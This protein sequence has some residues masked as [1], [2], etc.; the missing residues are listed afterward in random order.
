MVQKILKKADSMRAV[1]EHERLDIR[2]IFDLPIEV[3]FGEFFDHSDTTICEM[4]FN[5]QR[6]TPWYRV[7]RPKSIWDEEENQAVS[8][9]VTNFSSQ[10]P[11]ITAKVSED[12]G[13]SLPLMILLWV[14]NQY[15]SKTLLSGRSLVKLLSKRFV[16]GMKP[17][18]VIQIDQ[19]ICI[20]L[21]NDSVTTLDKYVII[22]IN[23]ERVKAVIM[24]WLV[25]VEIYDPLLGITWMRLANCTQMFV[26]EKITIKRNDRKICT[27]PAQIYPIEVKLPVVVFDEEIETDE[28]TAD[29]VCQ[30]L[31]DQ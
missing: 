26:E 23:V 1:A 3:T 19:H 18:P 6:S 21:T 16:R 12:D 4:A 20:S 28:W 15:L 22:S 24:A 27:V 8:N 10:P 2:N 25:D 7:Q 13:M 17:R 31:H 14:F 30:E 11:Q 9:A 5:M 29:D